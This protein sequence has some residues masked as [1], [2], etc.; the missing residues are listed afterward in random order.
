V[1]AEEFSIVLRELSI[2]KTRRE[3]LAVLARRNPSACVQELVASVTQA[4]EEGTP[5]A[6]VLTIQA[7]VSRQRRGVQAEEAAN[8]ASLQLML[9]MLLVFLSV[10]LL[11]GG[12]LG[13]RLMQEF[14]RA[15]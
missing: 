4:E 6:E 15:Q 11:I 14:G 9:P 12:P 3:A 8:R 5:L 2:G 1:L 7:T 13:L 10:L